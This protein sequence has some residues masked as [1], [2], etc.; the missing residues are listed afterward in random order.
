MPLWNLSYE[1]VENIK[2]LTRTK[3]QEFAVLEKTP[4]KQLWLEDLKAF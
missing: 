3:E 4:I 1:K 2:Q